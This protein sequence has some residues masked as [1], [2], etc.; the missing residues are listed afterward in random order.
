MRAFWARLQ[1]RGEPLEARLLEALQGLTRAVT[2]QQRRLAALAQLLVAAS[3]AAPLAPQQQQEQ[4]QQEQHHGQQQQEQQQQATPAT[5]AAAAAAPRALAP[6]LVGMLPRYRALVGA[7]L[8]ATAPLSVVALLRRYY[9]AR[10]GELCAAM[11]AAQEGRRHGGGGGDGGPDGAASEGGSDDVDMAEN[12]GGAGTGSG[13]DDEGAATA[14]AALA[15]LGAAWC[16]RVRLVAS[17]LAALGLEAAGEEAYTAVVGAHVRTQLAA[18]APGGALDRRVLPAARR[19]ACDAP[20]AFLRLLLLTG[21][22]GGAGSGGAADAP[23]PWSPGPDGWGAAEADG[24]EA[25]LRLH[26]W[27][28]RLAYLLLEAVGALRTAAMFDAVVDFPDSAPAIQ[29]LAECLRH[30]VRRAGVG[31]GGGCCASLLASLQTGAD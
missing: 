2:A 7:A 28:L 10:L 29:D 9:G 1:A 13:G 11:E 17:C 23:L 4:Q 18:L 16:G 3:G 25:A 22:R 5:D 15:A 26:E 21:E 30:T 20:L 31:G 6:L 8:Q 12:G 19:A 14:R 24:D 27:R